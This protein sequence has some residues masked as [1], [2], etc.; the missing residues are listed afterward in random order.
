MR[1]ARPTLFGSKPSLVGGDRSN[2]LAGEL[3]FGTEEDVEDNLKLDGKTVK[4]HAYVW[5][6]ASW[7]GYVKY[8]KA[9]FGATRAGWVS[10]EYLDADKCIQMD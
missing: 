3:D 2:S 9:V 7:T 8:I 1:T 5:H 10:D 6:G 4:Y